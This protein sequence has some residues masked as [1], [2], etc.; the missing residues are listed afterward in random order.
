MLYYASHALDEPNLLA[1]CM[2]V[3][4]WVANTPHITRSFTEAERMAELVDA[5]ALASKAMVL[6]DPK[7]DHVFDDGRTLGI[8]RVSASE[9]GEA[10]LQELRTR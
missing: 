6:T 4:T 9:E 3:A 5:L 8:W 7:N 10:D 1:Q 2:A